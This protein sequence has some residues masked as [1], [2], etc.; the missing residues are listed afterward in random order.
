MGCSDNH[1]SP[2]LDPRV[3]AP[4]ELRLTLNPDPSREAEEL[5]AILELL[6]EDNEQWIARRS[7][8]GLETPCCARCGGV[9]YRAPSQREYQRGL[10]QHDG[11]HELFRLGHGNCG[12]IVAF[13]VAAARVIDGKNVWPKIVPGPLGPGSWHAIIESPRGTSDPTLEMEHV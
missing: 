6:A 12:S 11:A 1:R 4:F 3:G 2:I 5:A 13:D 9:R 10:V 8:L 7:Q